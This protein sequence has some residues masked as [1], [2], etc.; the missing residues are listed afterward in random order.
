MSRK[1]LHM[2]W[3]TAAQAGVIPVVVGG[4]GLGKTDIAE[5]FARTLGR[6]CVSVE[7]GNMQEEHIGGYG[8]VGTIDIDG[9]QYDCTKL[10]PLDWVLRCRHGKKM[11]LFLDELY[12]CHPSI[13]KTVLRG[14]RDGFGDDCM[15]M[16]ATNPVSLAT[17]GHELKPAA[18][19]RLCI[20]DWQFEVDSWN[21]GMR[22]GLV[23]PEP[24][25]AI[26][27]QTWREEIGP[28]G[29][30]IADFLDCH[31]DIRNVQPK[32]DAVV[33]EPFPTPRSWTNAARL[34]AA[35]ASVSAP[36]LVEDI[37]LKGVVGRAAAEQF[38]A[39][40]NALGLPDPE[41]VLKKV[42]NLPWPNK[43]DLCYSIMSSCLQAVTERP[44]PDRWEA[45][46]D[47][48]EHAW[49]SGVQEMGMAFQGKVMRAASEAGIKIGKRGKAWSEML[50]A[51]MDS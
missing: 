42:W 2:A 38:W 8:K 45:L 48:S 49:A 26:L 50:A 46:F 25:F 44:S 12:N 33:I 11:F 51:R 3:Q 30:L 4:V 36:L 17:D 6:Q 40:L 19:N 34:L 9:V 35:A 43:A 31:G 15:V 18:V 32:D 24:E 29:R 41:T 1:S 28:K 39:W 37:L 16:C 14:L 20:M 5:A 23:F 7:L 10:H 47:L 13:Q 21:E 27:P 22:N